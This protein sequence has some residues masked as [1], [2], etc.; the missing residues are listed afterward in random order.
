MT[1]YPPIQSLVHRWARTQEADKDRHVRMR[2]T[3][4]P[5]RQITFPHPTVSETLEDALHEALG[6]LLFEQ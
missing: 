3:V 5:I 6:E 2:G 4:E 1:E